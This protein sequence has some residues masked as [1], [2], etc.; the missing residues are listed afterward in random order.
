MA[1]RG[2]PARLVIALSIAALLAVFLLYTSIAGGGVPSLEPSQ[3]AGRTGKVSLTGKVA[4]PVRRAASGARFRLRDIDGRGSIAVVY[5]DTLPD[6][7]KLGRHISLDGRLRNGVFV[8]KPGT[9]VTK[10][11]SKYTAA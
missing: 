11:P 2:N 3:L 9:M 6:Q 7:F 4:G 8:G 1:R 5:R 10:C